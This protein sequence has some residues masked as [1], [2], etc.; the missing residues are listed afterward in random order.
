MD[1]KPDKLT[2]R[3]LSLL[4]EAIESF[5]CN[6]VVARDSVDALR[7]L[8]DNKI[9]AVVCTLS[10]YGATAFDLLLAAKARDLVTMP[11]IILTVSQTA[12]QDELIGLGCKASGAV[13]FNL[14]NY[15]STEEMRGELRKQIVK[16]GPLAS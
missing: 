12:A 4:K 1:I 3:G 16:I 14:G 13:Y 8:K 5:G 10:L 2:V 7:I 9:Q 6:P 11:F 15:D